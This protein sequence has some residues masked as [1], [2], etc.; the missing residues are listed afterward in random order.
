M[1]AATAATA[2]AHKV[3]P[4]DIL[5]LLMTL[6]A[7]TAANAAERKVLA[8][9]ATVRIR[10]KDDGAS[11]EDVATEAAESLWEACAALDDRHPLNLP[12]FYGSDRTKT[13]LEAIVA[14]LRQCSSATTAGNIIVHGVVGV[15]K[16][17]MLRAA[18]ILGMLV[19]DVFCFLWDF[20]TDRGTSTVE[21]S[22]CGVMRRQVVEVLGGD[23]LLVRVGESITATLDAVT[24]AVVERDSAFTNGIAVLFDEIN[25]VYR[26]DP[27]WAKICVRELL[28]IGKRS[29]WLGVLTGSAHKLR[30]MV[31]CQ[32]APWEEWESLNHS[33]YTLHGVYPIRTHDAMV[34]YYCSRFDVAPEGVPA[35]LF[36]VTGGVGRLADV[37]HRAGDSVD[38]LAKDRKRAVEDELDK[39]SFQR[40]ASL[41]VEANA[42]MLTGLDLTDDECVP[43][44]DR[45]EA[46]VTA[47]VSPPEI[48]QWIDNGLLYEPA[49]GGSL[50]LLCPID[51]EVMARWLRRDQDAEL[52][53]TL[54]AATRSFQSGSAGAGAEVPLLLR[55]APTQFEGAEYGG[56]LVTT[57]G[58]HA[59]EGPDGG[60]VALAGLG[61]AGLAGK[62]YQRKQDHGV[63]GWLL[64]AAPGGS[65]AL[66]GVQIKLGF[67]DDDGETKVN[68]TR[69]GKLG[70][71]ATDGLRSKAWAPVEGGGYTSKITSTSFKP[72]HKH[73]HVVIAKA[74][75][76]MILLRE[77]LLSVFPGAQ[78]SL[79]GIHLWTNKTVRDVDDV[80]V[81][82]LALGGPDAREDVPAEFVCEG[83]TVLAGDEFWE[84]VGP[85][86]HGVL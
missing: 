69:G 25:V 65:Y 66:F 54:R 16:T 63:D 6:R 49:G 44:V 74:E 75:A 8:A 58:V 20:S 60:S 72:S 2:A 59:I 38:T 5:R 76:G 19:F 48:T 86:V 80:A 70:T 37:A 9:V 79:G 82:E 71:H 51:L 41:F 57:D 21:S 23:E 55:L 24:T 27:A 47:R 30:D 42:A 53:H 17:T 39:R 62:I 36:A 83:L 13:L 12:R 35:R 10:A 31:F 50:E 11:H 43:R 22:P 46:I 1:A 40:V 7:G 3:A 64:Q 77:L 81:A 4:E 84:E 34:E 32:C 78:L 28:N 29:G 26:A 56:D 85:A 18:A 68:F 52:V 45:S 15:G 61:L 33:V 14:Q 67:E 73:L